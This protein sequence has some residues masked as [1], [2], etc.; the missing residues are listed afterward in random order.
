MKR[1]D[2][3]PR[4]R[5][6]LLAR[7][8]LGEEAKLWRDG[9]RYCAGVIAR[10]IAP[11]RTAMRLCGEGANW[12]EAVSSIHLRDYRQWTRCAAGLCRKGFIIGILLIGLGANL[13]LFAQ[14]PNLNEK[15]PLD[16]ADYSWEKDARV[17]KLTTDEIDTL[18]RQGFVITKN[19]YPQIFYPYIDGTQVFITSD[20]VINAYSVLLEDSI[21]RMERLRAIRLRNFLKAAWKELNAVEKGYSGDRSLI[22]AA[23]NRVR[24]VIGVALELSTG[25][26]VDAPAEL[27]KRID[28]EAQRVIAAKGQSKPEWLGKPDPG[29]LSIDY[30][31]FKPRG[32]YSGNPLLEEDFRATSW[33]QAIPF[34]LLDDEECMAFLFV[35]KIEEQPNDL[36]LSEAASQMESLEGAYDAL[37]G[38]RDNDDL[39]TSYKQSLP[40]TISVPDFLPEFRKMFDIH[41][42][43]NGPRIND[44]I[45]FSSNNGKPERSFRI[46]SA[47]RVPDALLFAM[48]DN[49]RG[50]AYPSGLEV[51]ALMGS[52]PARKLLAAKNP[53]LLNIIESQA[54]FSASHS[55]YEDFLENLSLLLQAPDKAAPKLFHGAAWDV[56]CTQTFLGG[57]AQARH[58]WILQTKENVSTI[59]GMME[60]PPSGFVEPVPEF[61]GRIGH[62]SEES[63]RIFNEQGAFEGV[64]DDACDQIQAAVRVLKNHPE[65]ADASQK[66]N[67]TDDEEMI[68]ISGYQLLQA[69]G[70]GDV[71]DGGEQG[72]NIT[73]LISALEELASSL[74]HDGPGP[75]EKLRQAISVLNPDPV[76]NWYQFSNLCT[77][78]EALS[79]KQLRGLAF[80]KDDN[81]FIHEYGEHLARVM[82]YTGNSYMNPRDDAARIGDIFSN[83]AAAG[84]LHIGIGRPRKMYLLYPYGGKQI[85]VYGAV[86]PYYEFA[87]SERLTDRD[88]QKIEQSPSAPAQ[89]DWLQVLQASGKNQADGMNKS[90]AKK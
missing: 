1:T 17:H 60:S 45:A 81:D 59:G 10:R 27:S 42:P 58:A 54:K 61:F 40:S 77:K 50:G 4:W 33:L 41:G 64:Y 80:N 70:K 87:G 68:L 71:I 31:R 65:L 29:F 85:L 23:A 53:N 84:I 74:D 18:R 90:T 20:T 55:L 56:K 49:V 25:E 9:P 15:S 47:R 22:D 2:Y 39:F 37:L 73:K 19:S 3:L 46:L 51:A 43:K 75:D 88:W 86:S 30:S 67:F 12:Q 24:M 62:L 26:K 69:D 32:F 35:Y 6:L 57:W 11:G 78:L 28:E 89:P 76:L 21:L 48:T 38:E 44:Q 14:G 52:R 83:P 16:S 72:K 79:Q 36:I 8:R 34:R 82:F 7:V 63:M 66:P 13:A 5:A